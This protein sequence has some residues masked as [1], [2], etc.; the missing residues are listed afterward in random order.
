MFN[1]CD[2]NCENLITISG[3]L[4]TINNLL[5]RYNG[6]VT[7]DGKM[8][9]YPENFRRTKE[10]KEAHERARKGEVTFAVR[11]GFHAEWEPP[12]LLIKQ[13]SKDFPALVFLL[14]YLD[15]DAEFISVYKVQAGAILKDVIP[16]R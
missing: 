8:I 4:E 14:N 10:S 7:L 11:M 2:N 1:N 3:N 16:S 5:E 12:L 13:M 15:D 9:P 6:D